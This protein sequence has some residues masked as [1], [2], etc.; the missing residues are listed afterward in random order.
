ML[1][2]AAR[3]VIVT[4]FTGAPGGISLSAHKERKK[5]CISVSNFTV[6]EKLSLKH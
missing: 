6:S 3:C 2:M 1:E 5:M 4:L